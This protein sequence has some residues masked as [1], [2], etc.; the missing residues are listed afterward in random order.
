VGCDVACKVEVVSPL[1]HKKVKIYR[2]A[3]VRR[4]AF[5]QIN[6]PSSPV[7]VVMSYSRQEEIE[8]LATQ[9]MREMQVKENYV[10]LYSNTQF[11]YSLGGYSH[12]ERW[13]RT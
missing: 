5:G 9:K 7:I 2:A 11:N 6:T 1:A 12:R 4:S 13:S 3:H 8:N 10:S